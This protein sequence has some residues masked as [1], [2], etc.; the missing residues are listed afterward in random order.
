M[1]IQEQFEAIGRQHQQGATLGDG[2]KATAQ[3]T[4]WLGGITLILQALPAL[5]PIIAG[6]L[7]FFRGC[8]I[9]PKIESVPRPQN[10]HAIAPRLTH[11]VARTP[12]TPSIREVVQSRPTPSPAPI[13]Q[14]P[15]QPAEIALDDNLPSVSQSW[16]QEQRNHLDARNPLAIAANQQRRGGSAFFPGIGAFP[17]NGFGERAIVDPSATATYDRGGI[18]EEISGR[19]FVG[20]SQM[21]SQSSERVQLT[22]GRVRDRF[23][24]ITASMVSL[25]KRQRRR[26]YTGLI[27]GNPPQLVLNPVQKTG[28]YSGM[29]FTS[30]WHGKWPRRISLNIDGKSLIG[31]SATSRE[32]FEFLPKEPRR[33][34]PASTTVLLVGD[35]G[36]SAWKIDRKN[37]KHI[38]FDQQWIFKQT[39]RGRGDFTWMTDSQV[40]LKGRYQSQ[41]AGA[42]TLTL[43]QDNP[44]TYR[45]RAALEANRLK[46]CVP[47]AGASRPTSIEPKFGNVFYLSQNP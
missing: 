30:T 18:Y 27:E 3:T 40:K 29:G 11:P 16:P 7:F 31:Q 38:N 17:T 37:D 4:A 35:G 19:T 26:S 33:V 47:Q 9:T 20:I 41:A 23:S 15:S 45:C 10:S 24:N 13:I 36:E 42:L 44:K 43:N 1:S 8:N 14:P 25:E 21:P 5:I 39:K 46:V 34:S 22:I 2:L 6:C 28:D 12:R 32:T